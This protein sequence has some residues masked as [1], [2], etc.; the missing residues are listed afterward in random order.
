MERTLSA[1][2]ESVISSNFGTLRICQVLQR[3][4]PARAVYHIFPLEGIAYSL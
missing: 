3:A 1:F 2:S 4:I